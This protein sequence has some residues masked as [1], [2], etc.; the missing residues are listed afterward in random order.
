M[1]PGNDRRHRRRKGEQEEEF[2]Q[3]VA[4]ALRQRF[5][6][7]QKTPAIGNRITDEK[8]RQSRHGKI[9]QYFYQRIDLVLRAHGPQ[10]KERKA[11]VH[12]QYQNGAQQQKQGVRTRLKVF[13][14]SSGS[15]FWQA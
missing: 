10:L 14:Q 15:H 1:K 12:G 5:G 6:I 11:R 13:H 2:H 8:V 7:D 4:I 9:G 3:L